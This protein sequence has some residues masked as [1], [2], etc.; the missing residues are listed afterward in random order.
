MTNKKG[1]SIHECFSSLPDP[2]ILKKTRHKMLD[3][4]TITICA[5]ISGADS[6]VEVETY[7]HCKYEWLKTFL[8]LPNVIPSHDTFGRFF[9]L[10][11]TQE[12]ETF[13]LN[14]V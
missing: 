13:F 4:I 14:W 2:R 10:V 7:G 3:I 6:W 11:S 8:E 5:V 9:S 1:L 12:L